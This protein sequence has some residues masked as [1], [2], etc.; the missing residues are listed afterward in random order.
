MAQQDET[1]ESAEEFYRAGVILMRRGR[2]QEALRALRKAR[3]LDPRET[4]Y[5]SQYGLCL[6]TVGGKHREG[7]QLC[8][9]AAEEEFYRPELYC[10]LGL[11]LLA[12]GRV[13][14]AQAAFREG[15]S[16]DPRDRTIIRELERMGVRRRPLFPFLDRR[17][18]LNRWPGIMRHR[19]GG[20]SVALL[21]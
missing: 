14:E 9:A 16:L 7:V 5:L 1:L 6:A 11:A 20:D 17:N 21:S 10:N 18:P 15:L 3:E 2:G 13:R 8:Q 19:L 12:G 4:R